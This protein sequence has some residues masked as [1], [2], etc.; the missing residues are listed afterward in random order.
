MKIL[1]LQKRL[2]FPANSGGK[3]RTLNVLR[4]LA[5]WHE[6]TYL[7]NIQSGDDKYADE[8]RDLGVR[9]ETIPWAEAPR[10]SFRFYGE[11]TRNLFSPHPFNVDKDFD[12]R[13][14]RRA[15]ELLAAEP[16]DLLIC[17]FVQMARN[18]IGLDAPAKLLFTHNVEAQIF[19]R[20]AR[21][22]SGW[23]R[24]RF[25]SYQWRK[26]RRFEGE[27]GKGFDGVVA[28]SNR[29]QQSFE[30]DY[31]WQHAHVIDTAVNVEY[32]QPQ[33]ESEKP[34]HVLFI[35]SLDWTPNEEGVEHFVRNVWP[36]VRKRHPQAVFQVVGRNPPASVTRLGEVPGVEVVGTVP[37][38][39]PYV[40]QAAVVVVPLFVGGGTRLKIFEAMA[41]NKA[42]VSTS[43]G[44]E[45]LDVID[46]EHI[47]ISDADSDFAQAVSELLSDS[48]KRARLAENACRLV[49][50]SFSAETVARQFDQICRETVAAAARSGSDVT[51]VGEQPD[52]MA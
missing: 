8:M 29:D 50:E 35:G 9:L 47:R 20:H 18:A 25:M 16:F 5:R 15:S 40:A 23:L 27:A 42:V 33:A 14:R 26:M 12:P 6:V 44:A 4:H 52:G 30:S 24:R 7:C 32:F 34:G 28:V 13:L 11:L 37:D 49:Q 1:F 43:L 36:E 45:G 2:L 22:G 41:M 31:G 3:I 48:P 19:R 21:N 39:R 51:S 46:G 10:G 17:D 38:V